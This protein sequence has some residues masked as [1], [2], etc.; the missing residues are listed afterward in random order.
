MSAIEC[1]QIDRNKRKPPG[2]RDVCSS[3][4]TTAKSKSKT[5]EV[6]R[7]MPS[8]K[9]K[10]HRVKYD[11]PFGKN[12]THEVKFNMPSGKNKTRRV[13]YNMPF[14][15]SKMRRVKYN[16]PSGKIKMRE[17]SGTFCAFCRKIGKQNFK[18]R[19][20]SV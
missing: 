2:E 1:S 13:K 9:N 4:H 8:G 5:R 7:N 10:T 6:K 15:K 11:M 14:G 19:V 12:K 18:I 3:N 20:Q 17:V 16:M